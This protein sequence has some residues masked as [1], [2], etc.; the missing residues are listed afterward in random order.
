MKEKR[1]CKIVQD[2]LPNFIENLTS[3]ETNEFIEEHLKECNDC[4]RDLEN[5]KKDLKSINKQDNKEINYIKSYNTRMK[6]MRYTLIIIIYALIIIILTFFGRR[7]IIF[8]SLANKLSKYP[9][10]T[11]Y[12]IRVYGY[13]GHVAGPSKEEMW[14]KDG[15]VLIKYNDEL[16]SILKDG[17]YYDY[18]ID[19]NGVEED[20][21]DGMKENLLWP[22]GFFDMIQDELKNP[23][24]ILKFS[25]KEVI[26]NGKKCYQISKNDESG[27]SYFL[28][29]ETG[30]I[31]RL[32]QLAGGMS[33]LSGDRSEIQSTLQDYKFEFDCVKDKDLE[34]NNQLINY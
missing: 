30:L 11:N 3:E 21:T 7:L 10:S 31:V 17:V 4:K 24:N 2:L 6:K 12:Y 34:I 25:L 18:V 13:Y 20:I 19:E 5:A 14:V 33:R 15:N 8:N 9:N 27:T 23:L 1:N 22:K 29:K 28:N 32:E 26:V 16:T